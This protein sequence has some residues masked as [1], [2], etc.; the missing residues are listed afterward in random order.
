[1]VIII[2][3]VFVLIQLLLNEFIHWI[4]SDE[5]MALIILIS[6]LVCHHNF[7]VL[8]SCFWVSHETSNTNRVDYNAVAG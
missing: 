2:S 1:M 5:L 7:R 3:G 6:Q 4:V 8:R